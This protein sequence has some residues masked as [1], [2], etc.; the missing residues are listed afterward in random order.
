MSEPA[1]APPSPEKLIGQLKKLL[2]V[3]PV[4]EGAP[5]G[6]PDYFSGYSRGDRVSPNRQR[7]F[8]GQVIA[9]ALMAATR[10]V[11]EAK[12]PHSL[13]AY[14]MRAGND[15]LP[16]HF[17]VRRDFDGRSF[18]TRRVIALQNEKPILNLAAS[19][20]IHEPGFTHQFDMPDVPPPEDLAP[21]TEHFAKMAK[22]MP[23]AIAKH[24]ARPRPLEFRPVEFRPPVK[25]EKRPPY[26]QT[27][28]RAVSDVG[29]D[30]NMQTAI[31]A[32]ASDMA[33]LGTCT[34]PHGVSWGEPNFVSAS[35]D[36]SV[37]FHEPVKMDEWLLYST[38]SPWSGHARGFNR[39]SIYSRDGK[40]VASVAQ[41][42]LVR[43]TGAD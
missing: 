2:N 25:P 17:Q 22:Y 36:H 6:S 39:G 1:K 4:P 3:I 43:V 29:E 20:H 5:D 33:L 35:L 40:L 11:D 37:W 27:W 14:F 42:G 23:P 30:T 13:H 26:A 21:E 31:L 12:S 7:M 18:S 41:E 32:F 16:I 28:F 38:D 19:F 8:G 34:L 15:D 24:M 9:Q 10:T